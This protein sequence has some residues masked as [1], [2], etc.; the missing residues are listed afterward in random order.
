VT[1]TLR[2]KDWRAGDRLDVWQEGRSV[3]VGRSGWLSDRFGPLQVHVYR[4]R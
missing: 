3:R 2:V 4:T 1:A